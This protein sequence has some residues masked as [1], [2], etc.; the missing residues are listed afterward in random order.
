[1]KEVTLQA[2]NGEFVFPPKT[3][4]KYLVLYF[5]PKD[6]TPGCTIE[7][8]DFSILLPEF[9]KHNSFVYGISRDS[10]K[11]HCSFREK[12]N[13]SVELI[14]DP[15]SELCNLFEVIK[16][17]KNYGKEYLG[18]ERSTFIVD[19]KGKIIKEWR[20]V[21]VDGHADEVLAEIKKR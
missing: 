6:D 20:G 5:Y 14:S 15:D 13:Y 2:T 7:G 16:L 18:I 19:A 4:Y 3:D 21:K 17:K 1:M 8:A 10:L 11:S 9:I 12:Q